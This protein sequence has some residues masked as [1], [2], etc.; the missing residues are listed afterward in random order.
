MEL[1]ST[2]SAWRAAPSRLMVGAEPR[3][4]SRQA[5]DSAHGLFVMTSTLRCA[6]AG[7]VPCGAKV[8]VSTAVAA[9][10]PNARPETCLRLAATKAN[11]ARVA[12]I[13]LYSCGQRIL[14]VGDG[15]F[16]FSLALARALGGAGLVATS[17]ESLDTLARVYG[18]SCTDTLRELSVLGARV[19]HGVDAGELGTTL[20]PEAQPASGFDRIVW[21]FPCVARGSDGAVLPGAGA[22][23]DARGS[24]EL[25]QNR[26]LIARFCAAAAA[27]LGEGGEVHVTHKVGLQQWNIPQQGDNDGS[28]ASALEFSGAVV[29]D[30]AAYPPYRPRKAFAAKG[31]PTT[32]AQT[33]VFGSAVGGAT[34]AA[35]ATLHAD[36]GLVTRLGAELLQSV[37]TRHGIAPQAAAAVSERKRMAD[38]MASAPAPLAGAIAQEMAAGASGTK[39]TRRAG[40]K[41]KNKNKG[42]TLVE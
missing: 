1:K 20:P 10:L 38:A 6:L 2:R 7:C 22:G 25:E 13:G 4:P 18:T 29:F 28:G 23:A 35:G 32:D 16:S 21:N 33:F 5:V 39:K 9:S 24:A 3:S 34:A 12:S 40:K 31:F 36:S 27:R 37:V 41:K 11:A 26:Q 17:Y 14:T 42:A 8:L 30:R 19:V 15:D